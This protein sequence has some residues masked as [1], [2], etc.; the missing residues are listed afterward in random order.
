MS[1]SSLVPIGDNVIVEPLEETTTSAGIIIPDTVSKEK[2]RKGKVVAVG[3]GKRDDNGVVHPIAVEIGDTVVF[4]QYAPTEI[5]IDGQE[6]YILGSH[7]LLAK[8]ENN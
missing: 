1:K 6:Y 5:K 3:E 4:T 2:P 8:I 7:S